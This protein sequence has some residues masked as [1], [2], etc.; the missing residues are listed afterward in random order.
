MIGVSGMSTTA[1]VL[2]TTNPDVKSLKDFSP[3][4]RIAMPGIKTSLAA[5]VLQ[6][7]VAKEFGQE[8]YA[9]STR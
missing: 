3:K 9:N 8:N 5:V 2:N 6:M 4:D 7:A 1:L